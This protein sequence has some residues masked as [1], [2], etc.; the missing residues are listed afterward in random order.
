MFNVQIGTFSN[1]ACT[2]PY[3][4]MVPGK[5]NTY[6]V[7]QPVIINDLKLSCI[8]IRGIHM[9]KNKLKLLLWK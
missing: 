3:I 7:F 9:E 1:D 8:Y 2:W 5:K 6:K 4:Y